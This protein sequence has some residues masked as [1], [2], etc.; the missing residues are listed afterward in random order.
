MLTHDNGGAIVHCYVPV[1]CHR[2]NGNT[3]VNTK[4]IHIEE[5][6]KGKQCNHISPPVPE[7][8]CWTQTIAI[9]ITITTVMEQKSI[10][11]L[12]FSQR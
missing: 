5:A 1:S 11:D 12:R 6:K 9:A 4:S 8:P 10:W 3:E 7:L 2:N